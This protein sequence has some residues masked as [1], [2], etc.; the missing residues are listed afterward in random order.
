M[1]SLASP[2]RHRPTELCFNLV[3]NSFFFFHMHRASRFQADT[4]YLIG[5]DI[6]MDESGLDIAKLG[7]EF[8]VGNKHFRQGDMKLKCLATIA[9]VYKQS[10][11]ESAVGDESVLKTS[12]M[13]SRETRAQS[14]TREDLANGKTL[15]LHPVSTRYFPTCAA[16]AQRFPRPI[17]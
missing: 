13:E 16:I 11:E 2:S 15:S 3:K 9:T 14:H 12:I 6:V 17:D 7:L 10:N 8:R 4:D 1:L 5:P